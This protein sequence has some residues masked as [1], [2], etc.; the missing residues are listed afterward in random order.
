MWVADMSYNRVLRF[1]NAAQLT[2]TAPA[3]GALGTAVLNQFTV[4]GRT[5]R[6]FRRPMG[7]S[8]D[9]NESLWVAD[10]NNARLLKFTPDSL[11]T[12][13]AME[14]TAAGVWRLRFSTQGAGNFIVQSS[15]DLK[16]WT[17]EAAYKL[18]T[19]VSQ[20]HERPA[21]GVSRYFRIYEP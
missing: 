1:E 12:V 20:W 16:A 21:D 10:V 7:V 14:R 9:A 8:L 17:D 2:N 3:S 13:E 18:G 15:T 19:G 11:A 5:R 6:V 4:E